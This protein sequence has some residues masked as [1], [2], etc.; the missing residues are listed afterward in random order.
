MLECA[1]DTIRGEDSWLA[2]FPMI[3]GPGRALHRAAL[4]QPVGGDGVRPRRVQPRPNSA[5]AAV[6]TNMDAS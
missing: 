1:L 5:E 2:R 4:V 3:A 6:H